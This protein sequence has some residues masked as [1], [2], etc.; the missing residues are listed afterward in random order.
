LSSVHTPLTP[1]SFQFYIVVLFSDIYAYFDIEVTA[2]EYKKIGESF[3][4]GLFRGMYED[5]RLSEICDRCL[6]AVSVWDF[7]E[8]LGA[9]I[10]FR[11][12]YPL[13]TRI[14]HAETVW[15]SGCDEVTGGELV[16]PEA[17]VLKNNDG[18]FTVWW[19]GESA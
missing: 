19:P 1:H 3:D 9:D 6:E 2:E 17:E 16:P 15:V 14:D 18:T 13:E 8:E 11:F 4:T 7:E 10:L 5:K 12:D